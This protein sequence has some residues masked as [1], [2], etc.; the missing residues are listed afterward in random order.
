M[1]FP[2][3][4]IYTASLPEGCLYGIGNLCKKPVV[5]KRRD[6]YVWN[7]FTSKSFS[8]IIKNVFKTKIE[9][10]PGLPLKI[11]NMDSFILL[12]NQVPH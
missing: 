6:F 1:Y 5:I 3:N 8:H 2:R 4:V 11:I 7:N 10:R 9:A 12:N